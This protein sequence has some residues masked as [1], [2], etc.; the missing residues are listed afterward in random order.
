MRFVN[1]LHGLQDLLHKD[2]GDTPKKDI[3]FC[4]RESGLLN[5]LVPTGVVGGCESSEVNMINSSLGSLLKCRNPFPASL[6][7][8]SQRA[9][10]PAVVPSE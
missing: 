6:G 1:S 2:G 4:S 10:S 9:H 3:Q 7:P 8:V 5:G